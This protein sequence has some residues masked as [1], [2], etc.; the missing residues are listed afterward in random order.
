M[1]IS[2]KYSLYFGLKT[3]VLK[4]AEFL[5][6]PGSILSQPVP[7]LSILG[8]Y[9]HAHVSHAQSVNASGCSHKSISRWQI[10]W[11]YDAKQR[12]RRTGTGRQTDRKTDR[13]GDSCPKIGSVESYF[14]FSRRRR[15][16]QRQWQPSFKAEFTHSA[17]FA[18]ACESARRQLR[19]L[20]LRP[21]SSSRRRCWDLWPAIDRTRRRKAAG[22]S[23]SH[24]RESE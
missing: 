4:A 8:V 13:P 14:V 5:G 6:I 17:R 15:R 10:F 1:L 24:D 16:R 2:I 11:L 12:E 23:T 9:F 21:S 18:F 22:G 7:C 20:R 19:G 3:G